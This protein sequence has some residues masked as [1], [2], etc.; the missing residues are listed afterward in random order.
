MKRLKGFEI[1]KYTRYFFIIFYITV[2]P[3]RM[4]YESDRKIPTRMVVRN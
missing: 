3:L 2:V 1:I 4:Y